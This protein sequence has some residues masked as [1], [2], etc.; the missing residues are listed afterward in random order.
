[1]KEGEEMKKYRE[2]LI[3]GI[4]A[5]ALVAGYSPVKAQTSV[6]T[7]DISNVNAVDLV[8]SLDLKA[9]VVLGYGV[10][11]PE[12]KTVLK[13]ELLTYSHNSV[14][15]LSLDGVIDP[16]SFAGAE[17]TVELV[18]VNE[19]IDSKLGSS[20]GVKLPVITYVVD[21]YVKI[22]ATAGVGYNWDR[23]GVEGIAGF[24]LLS[25]NGNSS[26]TKTAS[27]QQSKFYA[28]AK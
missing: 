23:G 28:N 21:H 15:W 5:V 26:S 1:M 14:Q 12:I 16:S 9:G 17:V 2:M 6:T 18:P 11:K 27:L 10:G 22:E 25:N 4:I 19:W 13:L 7:T 20:S 3:A 24:T 8:N